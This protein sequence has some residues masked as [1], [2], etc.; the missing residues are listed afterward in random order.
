[1]LSQRFLKSMPQNNISDLAPEEIIELLLATL[2]ECNSLVSLLGRKSSFN[3]EE[4]RKLRNNL[5]FARTRVRGLAKTL[6]DAKR[7]INSFRLSS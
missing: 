3:P 4:L 7:P 1:M 6:E 2:S 5:M